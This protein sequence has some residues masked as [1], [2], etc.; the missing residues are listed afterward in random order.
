MDLKE[1]SIVDLIN[2]CRGELMG[3]STLGLLAFHVWFYVFSEIP[4]LAEVEHNIM[5]RGFWFVDV[6]FLISGLGLPKSYRSNSL[7]VYYYRRFKR[8]VLPF[9]V[10]GI[11][12]A[13]Y[14][15]WS[16]YQFFMSVTG[17][18]FIS[19]DVHALLWFVP[20]IALCYLVFPL[21]YEIL[22]RF[23]RP[24]LIT[25]IASCLAVILGITGLA[26]G[27]NPIFIFRIPV[28]L[29]GVL[30]YETKEKTNWRTT[31]K[32]IAISITFFV[33][34]AVLLSGYVPGTINFYY[35]IS[36]FIAVP[37]CFVF[38]L[39]AAGIRKEFWIRRVFVFLGKI[40]L[41]SYCV[42]SLFYNTVAVWL[43]NNYIFRY[44]T[45]KPAILLNVVLTISITGIAWLLYLINKRVFVFVECLFSKPEHDEK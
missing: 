7:M 32:L 42:Q 40:S 17:I 15:K 20:A 30:L 14:Y 35:L 9:L 4:V 29:F 26:H 44:F 34:A 10:I 38:A 5:I 24:V 6:F 22:K 21:Y 16:L 18:S 33:G 45:Y 36:S 3:V 12:E 28:F 41:E 19:G 37:F 2:D 1:K 8:I 43:I 25:V 27:Y 23:E 31:G 13:F 39:I 11:I